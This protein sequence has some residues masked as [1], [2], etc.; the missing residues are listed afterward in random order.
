M[1]NKLFV[2]VGRHRQKTSSNCKTATVTSL[3]E[4]E[5]VSYKSNC[6]YLITF[7]NL[8]ATEKE[9]REKR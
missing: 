9:R 4:E 2:V 6:E 1:E 3:L 5:A 7:N 8:Q